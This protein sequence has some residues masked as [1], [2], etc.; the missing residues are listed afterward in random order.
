LSGCYSLAQLHP[1]IA[2]PVDLGAQS[3]L[4]GAPEPMNVEAALAAPNGGSAR[5]YQAT[6]VPLA[7]LSRADYGQMDGQPTVYL[8]IAKLEA[9]VLNCRESRVP[10][11]MQSRSLWQGW[12][13]ERR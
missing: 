5:G 7:A 13:D 3:D 6:F 9:N 4:I 12:Q 1:L 11:S 8:Y 2:D 10:A